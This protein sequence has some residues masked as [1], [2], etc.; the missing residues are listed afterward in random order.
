LL[1]DSG[2]S[3]S[4]SKERRE[5]ANLIF[6]EGWDRLRLSGKKVLEQPLILFHQNALEH[7]SDRVL[8]DFDRMRSQERTVWYS[9]EVH[10]ALRG[11]VQH[12][13][14]FRVRRAAPEGQQGAEKSHAKIGE[15]KWMCHERSIPS[16]RK[17]QRS[18]VLD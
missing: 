2:T 11:F 10:G 13:I 18:I 5:V 15:G 16:A 6:R 1:I 12:E 9:F 4:F 3:E 8:V 7:S 14:E 17:S